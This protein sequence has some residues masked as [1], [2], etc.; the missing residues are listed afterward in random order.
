MINKLPARKVRALFNLK[1]GLWWSV[2]GVRHILEEYW[3]VPGVDLTYQVSKS[4]QDGIEKTLRAVEEGVDTII[5]IGGDGMVNSIGSALVGTTTALA[6]IPAGSGN[7]FARHFDIPL[8]PEKA[9]RSL[10]A[11]IRQ[12]IDVGFTNN[13]PFFVN[14]GLAWDAQIAEEFEKSPVRGILPYV[15]AGIYKYFTYE[16]QVFRLVV[17]DNELVV[18]K[19]LVLTIANLTM[20][21]GGAVIAPDACHNDGVLELVIVEKRDP[22]LLLR[23]I[24]RLFDG[25]VKESPLV[26]TRKL[27]RMLVSRERPDPIEVDGEL[28]EAPEEFTVEVRPAALEVIVPRNVGMNR[29][30]VE[31]A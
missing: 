5:V 12:R 13:H 20:Y 4:K 30:A 7:G 6:V 2:E 14:C 29:K 1:S 11:G 26:E 3:D 28:L 16:P 9:A 10:S 31:D 24:H 17:D 25:T 27:R 19:P 15:F 23:E 18:D 22:V 8:S 21:G